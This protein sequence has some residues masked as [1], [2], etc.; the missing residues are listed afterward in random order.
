MLH[1]PKPAYLDAAYYLSF[2]S[3]LAPPGG[4]AAQAHAY[5]RWRQHSMSA[6]SLTR[7]GCMRGADPIFRDDV[8]SR[9]HP[10]SCL[11]RALLLHAPAACAAR[12]LP[13]AQR[14]MNVSF[15]GV[16]R[17]SLG[18]IATLAAVASLPARTTAWCATTRCHV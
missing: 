18:I 14:R 5:H 8:D 17:R 11:L 7:L 13:P 3:A 16:R 9:R 2:P 6:M 4:G 1:I 15:C 12:T 10:T